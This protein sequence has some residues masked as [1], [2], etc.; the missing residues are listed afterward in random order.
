[1]LHLILH[2]YCI[3]NSVVLCNAFPCEILFCL[4]FSYIYCFLKVITELDLNLFKVGHIFQQKMK[5]QMRYL[6]SVQ[7]I[8]FA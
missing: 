8:L 2:L 6:Y 7:Y 5:D 3:G 1:M 4:Q